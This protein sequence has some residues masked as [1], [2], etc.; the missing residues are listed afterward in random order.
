MVRLSLEHGNCGGVGLRLRGLRDDGRL[1]PGRLRGGPRLRPARHRPQRAAGGSSPPGH[2]A[3]PLRRAGQFLAP[4]LRHLPATRPRG[5]ARGARKR[6]FHDRRVRPVPAE[7]VGHADRARISSGFLE[8]YSPT[9]EFLERMHATAY[10]EVQTMILQWARALQGATATPTSL[11]GDGFAESAYLETYGGKGIFGSWYV[12]LKIELLQHLR[13]HRR[14]ARGRAGN[15]KTWPK[16]SRARPGPPCSPSSTR[17]CCAPGSPRRRTRPGRRRWPRRS[18]SPGACG[19]GPSNC[20]GKLRPHAPTWW[21]RRSRGRAATATGHSPASRPRWLG[22][23]AQVSPR[24]RALINE[25]Y[26]EFWLEPGAARGGR[27]VPARG[28]YT[29]TGSGARTPRSR[30]SRRRHAVLRPDRAPRDAPGSGPPRRRTPRS[31]RSTFARWSKSGRP[32]PVRWIS[33]C[34]SAGSCAWRSS[35]PAP[36][37]ATWCS[38]TTARPRSTSPAARTRSRCGRRWAP[39]W[40]RRRACPRRW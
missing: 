1:A 6:R 11:D 25:R 14:S 18:R 29:A 30:P 2:G 39:R 37:G 8:R 27:G 10:R 38:S 26:G 31:A 4:A 19:S 32:S 12:T 22:R 28:P 17:S 35:M 16:C 36:N 3:P 9:V 24:Y 40:R 23:S 33:R 15:G 7:L 21:R 5:R 20:A 34:C 13:R